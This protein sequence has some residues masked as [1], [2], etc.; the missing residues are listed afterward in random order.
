[1]VWSYLSFFCCSR[2]LY[3]SFFFVIHIIE[4]YVRKMCAYTPPLPIILDPLRA[5]LTL[6][7]VFFFVLFVY[8]L[9]L[10]LKCK[11]VCF[12]LQVYSMWCSVDLCW[13][14]CCDEFSNSKCKRLNRWW[15]VYA[16]KS[17]DVCG[18]RTDNNNNSNNNKA[19][20]SRCCNYILK[21]RVENKLRRGK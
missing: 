17:C 2:N 9:L 16:W 21:N 6:V 11:W 14:I 15:L 12:C 8:C 13:C 5:Y 7:L 1:M 4:F 20:Y 10:F 19:P 3:C 18:A